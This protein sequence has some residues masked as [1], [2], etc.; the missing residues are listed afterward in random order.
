MSGNGNDYSAEL[1]YL[2]KNETVKNGDI[3]YTSGIGGDITAAIPV[4]KVFVNNNKKFVNF[5]VDFYQLKF[6]KIKK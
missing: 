2:P 5:F 6:V 1:D 3:V 4:G